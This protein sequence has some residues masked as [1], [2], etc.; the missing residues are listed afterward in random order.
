M[1]SKI[2]FYS[3]FINFGWNVLSQ[4]NL[5]VL[6][7]E[8]EKVLTYSHMNKIPN[9]LHPSNCITSICIIWNLEKHLDL[10]SQRIW[11]EFF[12]LQFISHF[13]KK[14]QKFFIWSF[15]F[16]PHIIQIELRNVFWCLHAIKLFMIVKIILVHI[17]SLL[18]HFYCTWIIISSLINS[19]LA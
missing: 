10:G 7:K 15:D 18:H 16:S 8:V 9:F 5:L 6:V 1:W 17:S 19:V 11:N 12:I 13:E 4:E 3:K 2:S 14:K